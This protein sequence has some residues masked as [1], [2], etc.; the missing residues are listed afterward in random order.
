MPRNSLAI[1]QNNRSAYGAF[2]DNL[3]E[4]SSVLDY[5]RVALLEMGTNRTYTTQEISTYIFETLGYP[6]NVGTSYMITHSGLNT[7]I[8]YGQ[9]SKVGRGLYVANF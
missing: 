2:R 9:I 3:H 1:R 7:G 6:G 4:G 5:I 8:K